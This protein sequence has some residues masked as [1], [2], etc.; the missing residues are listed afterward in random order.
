V[1]RWREA[2]LWTFVVANLGTRDTVG[3]LGPRARD[4]LGQLL[5]AGV[6]DRL[7][8]VR[9]KRSTLDKMRQTLA[10]AGLPVP[11]A[12]EMLFSR[13]LVSN[14]ADDRFYGW[15]STYYT[16]ARSSVK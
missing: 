4:R 13:S 1:E 14:S 12:T 6:A 3:V 11:K 8:V 9:G 7:E 2:L 15:P 10:Q 16:E 5:G